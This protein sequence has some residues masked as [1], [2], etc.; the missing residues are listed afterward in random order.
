MNYKKEREVE[1]KNFLFDPVVGLGLFASVLVVGVF[2]GYFPISSN[3]SVGSRAAS[4]PA[5]KIE[6]RA[7]ADVFNPDTSQ[8]AENESVGAALG[9]AIVP[10]ED[11][12][13]SSD[14]PRK[15]FGSEGHLK[16]AKS[17][18]RV[19]Y[20][21]FK[22]PTDQAF[23]KVYFRLTPKDSDQSGGVLSMVSDNLWTERLLNFDSQPKNDAVRIG[24]VGP[25]AA[26]VFK[27]VDVTDY[28]QKGR[29]YTFRI[30]SE[31]TESVD[32][33]SRESATETSPALVFVP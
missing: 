18:Q 1:N 10:A 32:Y 15:T 21:K 12:Y 20:V 11:G 27:R 5:L 9:M 14:T 25:V 2:A 4:V 7:A 22:V 26:R 19:A 17:P 24:P 6:E 29:T 30:S 3:L 13:V 31:G 8:A 23:S 33:Y 16:I 28:I